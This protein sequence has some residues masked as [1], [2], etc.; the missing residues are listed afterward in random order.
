MARSLQTLMYLDAVCEFRPF[1]EGIERQLLNERYPVNQDVVTLSSERNTIHFLASHDRSHVRLVH[2]PDPVR[3]AFASIAA[4]KVVVL[5][6][7]R[8]VAFLTSRNLVLGRWISSLGLASHISPY[9]FATFSQIYFWS[10][11]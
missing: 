2:T 5:L 7:V 8:Q 3:D 1:I 6:A 4:P 9:P 10:V 11:G